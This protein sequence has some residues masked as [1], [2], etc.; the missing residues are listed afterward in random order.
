MP[1]SAE[2]FVFFDSNIFIHHKPVTDIDLVNF[3]GAASVTVVI[4]PVILDELDEIKDKPGTE[5]RRKRS[6][7]A[8]HL[9]DQHSVSGEITEEISLVVSNLSIKEEIQKNDLDPLRNDDRLIA[10]AL[11]YQKHYPNNRVILLTHDIGPRV[12]G[13]S[14]GLNVVEPPENWRLPAEEDV[15]EKENRRLRAD[16]ERERAARP[17]LILR[18]TGMSDEEINTSFNLNSKRQGP[19]NEK[20]LNELRRMYP[21]Y[22]QP[23]ITDSSYVLAISL[24]SLM[25]ISD[26]QRHEYHK[27]LDKFYSEYEMYLNNLAIFSAQENRTIPINIEL[28]NIGNKPAE[29]VDIIVHFPDG[30]KL[31]QEGDTPAPPIKPE[32]PPEP[33]SLIELMG[34]RNNESLLYSSLHN[35]HDVTA[36]FKSVSKPSAFKLRKTNSYEVQDFVERIKH[37]H[38]K[39]IKPLYA[40][41]DTFDSASSFKMSY[42]I[43]ADNV[44]E[45]IKGVL[46]IKVV[47]T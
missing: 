39:K 14:F 25:A 6:R 12:R 20:I 36:T 38:I 2:V 30:F 46:N 41:F 31:Y 33:K 29:N 10:T 11:A 23:K 21:K 4:A 43:T 27:C 34:E 9:I 45:P 16:L 32:A 13:R 15:I 28:R 17:K 5:R 19:D 8:L 35:L 42:T 37:N 7:E 26:E 47:V 24:S 44:L 22:Q 1:A 18:L 40:I 3:L